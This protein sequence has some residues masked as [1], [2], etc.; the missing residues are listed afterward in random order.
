MQAIINEE[1]ITWARERVGFDIPT[2]A[3]I[4]NQSSENIQKWET[5]QK[6]PTVNQAINFAKKTKIPFGFLYLDTPPKME[7]PISDF[8]LGDKATEKN[9]DNANLYN[10]VNSYNYKIKWYED[11]LKDI[12][13]N[14]D[15]SHY[16]NK[17]NIDNDIK[18]IALDIKKQ[19]KLD[20]VTQTKKRGNPRRFLKI[21]TDKCENFG[22]WIVRSGYVGTNTNNTIP[23]E[24]CN[25]FALK[26]VYSPMIW[27]NPRSYHSVRVFT[28]AHE[29]AHLWIGREGLSNLNP[30]DENHDNGSDIE[31]QCNKV[32][33]EL[34]V[35]KNE[36]KNLWVKTGDLLNDLDK[37]NTYFG[38]SRF[39]ILNKMRDMSLITYEDYVNTR[40]E[41]LKKIKVDTPK[42]SGGDYYK[43]KISR[44]GKKFTRAVLNSMHSQQITIRDA[45]DLLEITSYEN[46]IKL[47][48]TL[49]N[50][51]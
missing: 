8:R 50:L 49:K 25:G 40:N 46:L 33:A 6:K 18:E 2:L 37:L 22:I 5:G 31:R 34:L 51:E 10:L 26:S 47:D 24:V 11:Y 14:Y 39:V 27:I 12:G 13:T 30:R 23:P 36:L 20:N 28:L 41:L 35:P 17:F 29:L 43:N 4:L 42:S 38:V 48:E 45:G 16:L 15:S 3:R 9:I 19:L 7:M 21:F 44:N 1:I 32:A